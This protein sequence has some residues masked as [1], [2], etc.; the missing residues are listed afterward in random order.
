MF[1]SKSEKKYTENKGLAAET[2][3]SQISENFHANL[4]SELHDLYRTGTA[5]GRIYRCGRNAPNGHICNTNHG[6]A[7]PQ[8]LNV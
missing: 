1:N 4:H 2:T 5:P 6:P 3:N 8:A 7:R